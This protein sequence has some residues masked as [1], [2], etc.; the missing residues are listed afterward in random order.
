MPGSWACSFDDEFNG[1]S[2]D[3]TKWTPQLTANS[4]YTT[5]TASGWPCYVDNPSTISESGGYLDLSVVQE[6]APVSC[7][8]GYST[9]FEA[10][11]V[12]TYAKFD[13]T[14]GAFEV[15]AELPPSVAKGLQETFW[16]YPQ[17]LT[18][19]AWPHSGEIDFAEFFSQYPTLDVPYIHYTEAAS[20]DPNVTAYNCTIN[21]GA[22]NTYGIDW[23]PGTLTIYLNGNVCL[24]DHPNPAAPLTSPEPF[25]D[26]FFLA[27]TVALGSGTDAYV[28]GTT[29]L[30]ATTLVDWVRDW[31]ANTTTYN[32]T[33]DGNGSTGGNV[34]VDSNSYAAG[35][36]ASVLGNTGG[37]VNTGY[38]FDDWN[39][40]ANGSGTSYVPGNT[41]SMPAAGV[42]LYAIWTANIS[43]AYSYAPGTGTGSAPASGSGLDGTAVTLAANTFTDPGH[44]FAGWS[45]GSVTYAAGTSYTLASGG[46]PI[47]LTAQWTPISDAYSYAPGTGTG[48]APASGSGLDGTAVTLAANT[49]TDPGHTFAGWSDGSVTYAAGTSYTLASGGTPIV[50]TA[51]W[52]PISD[53]YSYAPGT[54]T[55]SAPA[56]GS[57]LDGT[58]VTLAANTFTDPGHTFAGWSDGSVTYAAG[59]SYTLASGGTPIVLTAQWTPISDAYSYV[60]GTGTGSA[61]A[62]GSGLDGTAV[63]LAANTFTDPGHTFAG[64]SDGSV[65]YAA[66]TSYTL[67]SGGTPIVLT[68]QWTPISDAYSYAPGTGTGSAPA[69]GSGLD[70]TAVTLAANTFTDPG[71]T[72]AG[73]SDGSATYAAGT[74]YTLASGGT[75]IV[76]T[77][78]WT[79][80][81][82]AYSYA[83]GTGT[84]SA[85]A[86]GSGLDGTAVTLAAN[87]FTDPGH[88]FAGWSDGSVTYAAGTSYTLASGGTPIVLTAQLTPISDA[89]SYVPGTGTGSAPASG[90][91]LDGTA[92]TLAANTFTDPGHT[93]AG[94]S[95]GSATY[96]AGTSYTLASGGTP[97]V[98]TAQWTPISDAYSYVP[99]TGTGS[100]PASGSGLDG[101]AVTL[102]A[103]TFTDPGH[104]F[105]GWSDGSVTYAAGTS[106]TLASGGTPIVLTAQWTPISDAYSYAPGTGTGSAPASGSGLDGTAVTLAANT[107]TDPGH[108]FAG[109]SDGSVTYAAGT[110][111]TL[112]SGGT[113]IVL[114]AQWTP[115][116]DAYSYVPGTGTGS[117]PASGSGLDGTA[118]TLAANTFTD[119]GHTFAGWSDGSVTYAAGTSYTLASGGTPIVLTAQLTPISD[120]YSYVPGTGTGSAPASGSGLD[121]TAVTLA[122]NTFTDPGHTFAGWSDGSVTYAAGTSYTLASG[123]TPIVL[124]AQWTPI[125]YTVTYN[126]ESGTGS[127]ASANFTVGGS[128][129]T[130]P[131]PTRTGY[132]FAGWYTAASSGTLVGVGGASYSPTA[133]LT[134]YARWTANTLPEKT[135]TGLSLSKTSVTYGAETSETFTV[136]VTGQPGD[137]YPEGTLTVYNSSTQVCSQI[138]VE[139][140]TDSATATCSP[141]AI[142]GSV[143]SYSDVFAAYSPSTTSSSNTG[144]AYTASTSTP[145]ARLSVTKDTTTS[146]VSVTPTNV[147]SGNESAAVFTVTVT[148]H[149]G[150]AVPNGNQVT[151]KVG[152]ATC[153]VTLNAGTGTCTIAKSALPAGTYS[154]SATYAGDANLGGS[155]GASA[156]KLTVTS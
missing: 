22:F 79:P 66:G 37:L 9:P 73:W 24:V 98:L 144:Y 13:Q 106:Y 2:L 90:S 78:Q 67:A 46:T 60:P 133:S 136:T 36:T 33:Y 44:T 147:T 41:F 21:Q 5:G 130:L 89:Y 61:P 103:N 154:V 111:Y 153:T 19:G 68:A 108:T 96:A 131:T 128:A 148:T 85:P 53:A 99:G 65:T 112:A 91:G 105:A 4:G 77:A 3:T 75:P 16:L 155:S 56:S 29:Q 45:D 115:I 146:K 126:Y 149:N 59:T 35:A 127:P 156:T 12:S 109:W 107:F 152:S 40:A 81:S 141:T 27:L 54:G 118:V 119:P 142:E 121:G 34:P 64:W 69:S 74:S 72:F 101:T 57:G 28:P 25:N 17:T 117:A 8:D 80:I 6:A 42:T 116:S 52:T 97:I 20:G 140:S 132:T 134:I 95:D 93:F 15:N 70:G 100:A 86:S 14:Y 47:V 120:A 55:G 138:L 48:S 123:G 18:Y 76:L 151:V 124:T 88:T 63:T 50:L 87:T 62:S 102:A 11:M 49:F 110:S 7:A 43:D 71:H 125:V 94:W 143:G 104:T 139:K 92:V 113:P 129:L 38:S 26:P 137:G 30:P 84:G 82:D 51:Q 150:E 23:Q 122:A 10:G 39:T 135:T 31:T 32:V 83:P 1:T 58:A 114:T 145:A